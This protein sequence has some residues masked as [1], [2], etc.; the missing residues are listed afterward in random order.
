MA[1]GVAVVASAVGGIPEIVVDGETG[2]LVP[3]EPSSDPYGTPADP[4]AFARD[5]ADRINDLVR[6]PAKAAEMGRAGRERVVA[7]FSWPSIAEQTAAAYRTTL[8]E[9]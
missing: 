4:D 1:C 5:L 8:R 2:W 7:N 3:F 9:P 6:D